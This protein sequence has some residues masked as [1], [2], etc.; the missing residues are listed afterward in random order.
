MKIK[1]YAEGL[2][3]WKSRQWITNRKEFGEHLDILIGGMLRNHEYAFF[4]ECR[5]CGKPL[6]TTYRVVQLRTNGLCQFVVDTED[7]ARDMVSRIRISGYAH[8][9]DVQAPEISDNTMTAF[10]AFFK[11]L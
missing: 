11:K 4:I 7:E 3:A 8:M 5:V 6:W 10:K 1:L 2:E 9:L